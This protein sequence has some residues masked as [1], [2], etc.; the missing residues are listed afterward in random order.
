MFAPEGQHARIFQKMQDAVAALDGKNPGL[1]E[2]YELALERF[3]LGKPGSPGSEFI[4]FP[5]FLSGPSELPS[6][7]MWVCG[8]MCL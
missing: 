2:Q 5:G 1:K 4:S 6:V 8:L 3:R 7:G